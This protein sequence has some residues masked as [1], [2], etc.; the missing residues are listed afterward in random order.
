MNSD[1]GKGYLK[2]VQSYFNYVNCTQQHKKYEDIIAFYDYAYYYYN[3]KGQ[4]N[5]FIRK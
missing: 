2:C 3:Q 1:K 5:E 4:K